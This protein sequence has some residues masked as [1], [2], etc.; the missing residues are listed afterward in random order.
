LIPN[1]PNFMNDDY[2]DQRIAASWG[3]AD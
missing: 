1:N 3:A 2:H